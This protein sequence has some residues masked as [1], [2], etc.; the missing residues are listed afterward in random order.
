M[1]NINL[2][3]N[4]MKHKWTPLMSDINSTTENTYHWWKCANCRKETE[5]MHTSEPE[6]T[7]DNC[8]AKEKG[9]IFPLSSI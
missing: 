1:V 9:S 5:H 3:R 8:E 2:R 4:N 6:P 7:E